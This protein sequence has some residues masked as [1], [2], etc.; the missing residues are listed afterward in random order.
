M[1]YLGKIVVASA[2]AMI[3]A[4]FALCSGVAHADTLDVSFAISNNN[5]GVT[6]A[7]LFLDSSTVADFSTFSGTLVSCT[8]QCGP[9]VTGSGELNNG[10]TDSTIVTTG[11]DGATYDLVFGNF[12]SAAN[13]TTV[14]LVDGVVTSISWTDYLFATS[15]DHSCGVCLLSLSTTEIGAYN[16]TSGML[17]DADLTLSASAATPLP[18]T[19]PLF[20]GGLGFVGYLAKR[21]KKNATPALAAA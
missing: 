1:R 19:L 13:P 11:N 4:V 16:K 20:A 6:A 12:N 15:N 21:R 9:P 2:V 14:V 3:A 5:L 7:E 10:A 18:A 8:T 17:L